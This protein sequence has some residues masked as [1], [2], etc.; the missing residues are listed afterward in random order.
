MPKEDSM[1]GVSVELIEIRNNPSEIE[2]FETMQSYSTYSPEYNIENII[3]IM[4]TA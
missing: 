2:N 3:M 4:N 1:V